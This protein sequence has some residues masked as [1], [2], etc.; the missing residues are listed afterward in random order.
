MTRLTLAQLRTLWSTTG[1][2]YCRDLESSQCPDGKIADALFSTLACATANASVNYTGGACNRN[3]ENFPSP[4]W[5]FHMFCTCA[6]RAAVSSSRVARSPSYRPPSVA[7]QLNGYVQALPA[8]PPSPRWEN[9][10]LTC[11]SRLSPFYHG[12]VHQ[13][14]VRASHAC[15]LPIAPTM[16]ELLTCLRRLTLAKLRILRST[17]EFCT[18]HRDLEN[19]PSP[20]WEDG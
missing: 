17:T 16:G 19:F 6:C 12:T 15:K 5:D 4:Q 8:N 2:A 3:L 9:A 18:C 10:L 1:G 11:P 7:T 20:Q 13:G 14:T